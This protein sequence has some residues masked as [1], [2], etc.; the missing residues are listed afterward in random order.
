LTG[1][2]NNGHYV[3]ADNS[4][5]RSWCSSLMVRVKGAALLDRETGVRLM[6]PAGQ[7][8]AAP[9]AFIET[10]VITR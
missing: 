3:M 5:G 2:E 9:I 1:H 4:M 8:F 6:P 10:P 7:I